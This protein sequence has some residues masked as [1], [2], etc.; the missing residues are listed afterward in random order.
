MKK[1]AFVFLGVLIIGIPAF[2]FA[3]DMGANL[4]GRILIQTEKNGEAWYV[5]PVNNIR[6]YLGRPYDAFQIMRELGLGIKNVDLN[7]IP[8]GLIPQS[9]AD[10]DRDG[11]VD[12]LEKA[13][14]TDF[15]NPDTDKD[16][17]SDKMEVLNG[18]NPLGDG[19]FP[20]ETDKWLVERL[21]GRILLQVESKGEAWYLNP[22]DNKRYFLGR[23]EDAFGI[24]RGFGLGITNADLLKIPAK[25]LMTDYTK[26]T[27]FS[28][29]IPANWNLKETIK[30]TNFTFNKKSL[31][32][33]YLV[34]IDDLDA[35]K[36]GATIYIA[37]VEPKEVWGLK[38]FYFS[39][40]NKY[41]ELSNLKD[42]IIS[43]HAARQETIKFL[44]NHPNRAG[45]ALQTIIMKNSKE[46]YFIGLETTNTVESFDYYSSIYNE[47]VSSFKEK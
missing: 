10:T 11:L 30:P 4:K 2:L 1:I 39:S 22:K 35:K 23:P 5:N 44:E 14:G 33:E 42:T 29:K 31:P 26:N 16:T 34:S 45:F 13:I 43:T 17:Y 24:M 3:A 36:L 20:A 15:N 25:V 46:F 40:Q 6:Y 9:G 32:A 37:K 18:F 12:S 8:V 7:K 27:E 21:S 19:N 41:E 38:N 47:I 28:F